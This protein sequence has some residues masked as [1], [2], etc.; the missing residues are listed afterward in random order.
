[1][2]CAIRRSN[3]KTYKKENMDTE[4]DDVN[5]EASCVKLAAVWQLTYKSWMT[6]LQALK[7][8]NTKFALSNP[9]YLM[10]WVIINN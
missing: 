8:T 2:S 9:M 5:L 6:Y 3:K 7:H 10:T 4:T 1:M